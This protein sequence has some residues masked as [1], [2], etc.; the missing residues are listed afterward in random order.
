MNKAKQNKTVQNKTKQQKSSSAVQWILQ[1]LFNRDV[2]NSTKIQP[3]GVFIQRN[4]WQ[5]ER[6]KELRFWS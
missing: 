5:E 6:N 3:N 4:Y 2:P 1:I